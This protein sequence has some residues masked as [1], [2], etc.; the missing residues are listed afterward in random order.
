MAGLVPAIHVFLAVMLQGV[1]T[2]DSAGMT[3]FSVDPLRN[4]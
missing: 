2:R 3:N 1:D 4:R